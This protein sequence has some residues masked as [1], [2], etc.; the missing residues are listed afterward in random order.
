M[1]KAAEAD[2]VEKIEIVAS[3]RRD[4]SEIVEIGV[5]GVVGV[6][7]DVGVVGVVGVVRVVGVLDAAGNGQSM[8]VVSVEFLDAFVVV[9]DVLFGSDLAE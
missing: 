9:L 6:V 8:D 7:G 3:H 5:V 1:E 4:A 2:I